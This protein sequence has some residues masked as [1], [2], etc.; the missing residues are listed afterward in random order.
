MPQ[1]RMYVF[2]GPL[3]CTAEKELHGETTPYTCANNCYSGE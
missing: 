1:Y 3:V 2:A